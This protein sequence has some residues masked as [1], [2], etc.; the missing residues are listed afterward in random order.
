MG[1]ATRMVIAG[2]LITGLAMFM[3]HYISGYTS[4][5]W[6][7]LAPRNV[8][9]LKAEEK[10]AMINWIT[11][12]EADNYSVRYDTIS[13]D[14]DFAS[15]AFQTT[16]I[17][18]FPVPAQT[19]EAGKSSLS[20]YY[21]YQARIPDVKPDTRYYFVVLSNGTQSKEYSFLLLP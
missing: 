6:T 15:Y 5:P 11:W 13:H 12:S 2:M 8:G 4:S 10:G 16:I 14:G 20:G 18:V 1:T 7:Q 21:Y 19:L 3:D 9:M 17:D